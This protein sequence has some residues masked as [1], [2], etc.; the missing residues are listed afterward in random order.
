M[1]LPIASLV[2]QC[3][4]EFFGPADLLITG[5]APLDRARSAEIAF[6]ASPKHLDAAQTSGA[7]VLIV[8]P[9]WRDQFK[10]GDR[11]LWVHPDPYLAFAKAS[12]QLV[13]TTRIRPTGIHPSAVVDPTAQI[14]EGVS[15]GPL[16]VVGAGAHLG[17]GVEVG[18]HCTIG[19]RVM[20]GARTRLHAQVAVYDEC[21]IGDDC[22]LHSGVVIGADGFG[23]AREG[24]RWVKIPQVGRVCIGNR[25]EI[26]ANTTVDRGALDD[27]VIEDGVKLDNLIQIAHNVHVGEDTAMAGCV[28]IAG[29]TKIGKRCTLAGAVGLFGHIELADDVHISA[30]TVVSKSITKAGRYTGYFPFDEHRAWER[31]AAMIRQ[32]ADL[33][34]R[35][36]ALERMRPSEP[37]EPVDQGT[38]SP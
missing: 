20:V 18:A 24:S 7:G 31:N 25:V 38:D 2:A 29:S 10:A 21:V 37:T 12:Q 34:Q 9:A 6:V 27:T 28:G 23:Y 15:I 22:I 26:G 35:I 11:A 33:R 17:V 14:D 36:K 13:D 16:T 5:F 32:L 1:P 19:A 8:R 3:G 4:G 30:A